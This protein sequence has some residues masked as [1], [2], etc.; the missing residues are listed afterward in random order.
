MRAFRWSVILFFLVLVPSGNQAD[1]FIRNLI[2]N[3]SDFS[4]VSSIAVGYEYVYF[5]TSN[6]VIRYNISFDKWDD[7]LTGIEGLGNQVIHDIRA[8]FDDENVWVKTDAGIYKY[9]ETFR[10]W[11]P[12][13]ELPQPDEHNIHLLPDP[14]YFAPWGYNYMPNGALVDD[15]GRI[16]QITDIVK[17]NWTHLWLGTWGLGPARADET[18]R[19]IELLNYGLL[20]TNMAVICNDG[21][22]LWIGGPA[23]DSYR[24]GVTIY[25]WN[26]NIFQYIE[27]TPDLINTAIDINDISVNSR[28][29]FVAT[30][31]GLWVIDKNELT[32]VRRLTRRSGLTDDRVLSVL[33]TENNIY[34]GT[35]YGLGIIDINDDSTAQMVQ[36]IL[37]SRIIYC[38][39]KMDNDLWI[40]TDQGVFR[41]GLT[42]GRVERLT[43]REAVQFGRIFDIKN[44]SNKIWISGDELISIEKGSAEVEVF[45]EMESYSGVYCVAVRDTILALGTGKG[46]VINFGGRN[47]YNRLF[48]IGDGLLSNDIRDL[49]FDGDYLWLASDS[50]LTRFWYLNPAL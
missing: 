43:A 19:M 13:D 16:Y 41:K 49:I 37:P 40:G 3:Y 31:N 22:R 30:D 10:R 45:P 23:D 26:N 2:V 38:L 27:P 48:T 6:G 47:P 18:G 32:I 21:G 44:T 28:E 1:E 39:E 8:S 4:Y 36:T 17:D 9:I 11:D 33:A 14:H 12:D 24:N 34:A 20:G 42:T 29:A 35:E 46:L 7:P 15:Y 5:G 25:D 50:G